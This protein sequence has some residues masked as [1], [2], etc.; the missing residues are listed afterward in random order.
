MTLSSISKSFYSFIIPLHPRGNLTGGL[1]RSEAQ[2]GKGW[3]R[4]LEISEERWKYETTGRR[5]GRRRETREEWGRSKVERRVKGEGRVKT[6]RWRERKLLRGG[7]WNVNFIP[8]SATPRRAIR[9]FL[10]SLDET[11]PGNLPSSRSSLSFLPSSLLHSPLARPS[12]SLRSE[13]QT[14][15]I[16][17]FPLEGPS[18]LFLTPAVYFRAKHFR[19][20]LQPVFFLD[21]SGGSVKKKKNWSICTRVLNFEK[22]TNVKFRLLLRIDF[23]ILFVIIYVR[24]TL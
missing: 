18:C 12:S 20:L 15:L 8:D 21:V 11:L 17:L 24:Y 22:I 16:S 10:L 5:L 9:L 13:W 6:L 19:S 4:L 7:G 1:S 3:S 2:K 14:L 23:V